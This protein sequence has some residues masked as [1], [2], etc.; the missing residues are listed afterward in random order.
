[1]STT[2]SLLPDTDALIT[3]LNAL[4]RGE[5]AAVETYQ[6][7][8]TTFGK[9]APEG[10]R[11]CLLSHQLRVQKLIVRVSDLGG[12]PA[13]GSG[14]WGSFAKLVEGGAA[15]FGRTSALAALA[16]GEDHGLAHYRSLGEDTDPVFCRIV[17]NELLPEQLKSHALLAAVSRASC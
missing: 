10:L 5:V 6:Q 16:E 13:G 3:R 11:S 7:A 8:I 4:L 14:T 15:L 9:D 2:T 17:E 1:M 12:Q